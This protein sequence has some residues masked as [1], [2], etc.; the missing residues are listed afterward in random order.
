VNF[1]S[2]IS[3]PFSPDFACKASLYAI[4]LSPNIFVP[5]PEVI[6]FKI[7]DG[8][9]S[10]H[11]TPLALKGNA[12]LPDLAGISLSE[13]MAAAREQAPRGSGVS[14]GIP[15]EIG[16][17]IALQDQSV[18][19]P[20]DPTTTRWLVFIHV[21]DDLPL[22]TNPHGFISPMRGRGRLAEHAADYVIRYADGSEVRAAIRRRHQI[23]AFGRGWGENCFE[24][25][26]QHKVF[27]LHAAHEQQPPD[28]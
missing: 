22:E 21:T 12:V 19:V 4:I 13:R 10:P 8:P 7:Q 1:P 9:R 28:G 5:H 18:S 15:F 3:R 27:P 2:P 26:A 11:F 14:W 16:E 23:G 6:M 25:V 20:L 17:V 24:A